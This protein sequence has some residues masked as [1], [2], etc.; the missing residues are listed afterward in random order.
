MIQIVVVY[1]YRYEEKRW[2]PKDEKSKSPPRGWDERAPSRW[3]RPMEKKVVT[4]TLVILR[5][6]LT[7]VG[8]F[9]HLAEKKI[10][11]QQE[12]VFLFLLRDLIRYKFFCWLCALASNSFQKTTVIRFFFLMY[13]L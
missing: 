10:F 5:I 1:S 13:F 7:K 11:L 2:V 8:L 12:L 4:G 9:K 6:H 3:Q